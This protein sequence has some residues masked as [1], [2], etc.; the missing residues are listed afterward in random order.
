VL[1]AQDG[2][3]A[4]GLLTKLGPQVVWLVVADI[5]MPGISGDE[6]A[7]A[8]AQ[9]SPAVQVLLLSA[10]TSPP[11]DFA[12]SFLGKPFTPQTLVAT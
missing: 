5:V 6:L 10:Q 3:E 8:I 4:L 1:E 2:A 12:G 11:D 7:E 9:N